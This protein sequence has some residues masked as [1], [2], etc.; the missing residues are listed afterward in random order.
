MNKEI[1]VAKIIEPP[2]RPSY[3]KWMKYIKKQ[4]EKYKLKKNNNG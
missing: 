3:N 1:M 2:S 4:L